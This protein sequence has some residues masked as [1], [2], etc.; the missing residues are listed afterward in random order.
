MKRIMSASIFLFFLSLLFFNASAFARGTGAD[1]AK[2]SVN[3]LS[4][5]GWAFEFGIGGNFTL[6]TFQGT[7]LSVKRQLDSHDAVE[8]G[9]SGYLNNQDNSNS[10]RYNWGDTLSY[11]YSQSGSNNYGNFQLNLR[12]IYY[13]N[14]AGRVNFFI[15]AG[16]T[17]GYYRSTYDINS[18]ALIPQPPDPNIRISYPTSPTETETSWNAG[19]SA[20]AGV[21]Y[22]VLKYL[23]VH[24]RYGI[25]LVYEKTDDDLNYSYQVFQNGAL[26]KSTGS[27]TSDLHGL[28]VNPAYVLFG[29]SVYL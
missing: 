25:N 26:I 18:T 29:L 20:V 6:T 8:L 11:G 12:Y 4:G 15:G 9:I 22:F 28:H 23:S 10:T 13:L 7:V 24:A 5:P 2:T 27:Q 1:S 16:P 17:F 21:E 19:I 3:S 14:P